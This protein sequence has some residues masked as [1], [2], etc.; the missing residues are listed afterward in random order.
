MEVSNFWIQPFL[1]E[2]FVTDS[3]HMMSNTIFK[4]EDSGKCSAKSSL[5]L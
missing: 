1:I 3:M 5:V 2:M 4:N